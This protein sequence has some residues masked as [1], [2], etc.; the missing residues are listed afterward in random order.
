MPYSFTRTLAVIIYILF[1]AIMANGLLLTWLNSKAQRIDTNNILY[2]D[3][4]V[5]EIGGLDN[6]IKKIVSEDLIPTDGT[7]FKIFTCYERYLMIGYRYDA[8]KYG[9][10]ILFSFSSGSKEYRLKNRLINKI[11]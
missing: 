4:Q 9:A 3:A 8:G 11:K 6:C 1:V 5:S 7:F 10:I 2:S